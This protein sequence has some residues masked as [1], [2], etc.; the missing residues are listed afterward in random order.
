MR[1]V[2]EMPLPRDGKRSI[3]DNVSH[4]ANWCDG[5]KSKQGRDLRKEWMLRSV[6]EMITHTKKSRAICMIYI[7]IHN[8][9]IM[10][11]TFVLSLHLMV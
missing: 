6:I 11:Y 10:H 4:C 3:I 8:I 7:K 1:L 2:I 5:P 9:L